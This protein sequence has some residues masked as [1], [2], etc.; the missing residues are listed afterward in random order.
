MR[1]WVVA[2]LAYLWQLV[3]GAWGI[4]G[5]I[6]TVFY[7]LPR[8]ESYRPVYLVV[9]VIAFVLAAFQTHKAAA[10]SADDRLKQKDD[11][12][13]ALRATIA[14]F[15]EQRFHPERRRI[16]EDELAQLDPADRASIKLLLQRGALTD[17][18]ALRELNARGFGDR[19]SAFEGIAHRTSLVRRTQQQRDDSERVYGYRG[20]WTINPDLRAVLDQL[21]DEGKL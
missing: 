18:E 1:R 20:T 14:R 17:S 21:L 15:E 11:E 7:V 12:I 10:R 13:A 9:L 16:A 19:G 2:L 3:R 6:A 5:D 4:V 8:L